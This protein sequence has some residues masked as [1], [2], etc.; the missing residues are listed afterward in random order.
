MDDGS[1]ENL[2][3]WHN[4]SLARAGSHCKGFFDLP[5]KQG[6]RWVDAQSLCDVTLQHLHVVQSFQTDL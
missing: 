1:R 6:E 3:L 4:V 5:Q 2:Y